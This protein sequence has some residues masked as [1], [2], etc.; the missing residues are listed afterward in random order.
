MP[1]C[2]IKT[3][4]AWTRPVIKTRGNC[5]GV[6]VFKARIS[7]LLWQKGEK[8]P[9]Y[10]RFAYSKPVYS[11]SMQKAVHGAVLDAWEVIMPHLVEAFGTY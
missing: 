5:T 7:A 2:H 9:V 8:D 10:R 11:E 4:W 1:N 3:I 6:G